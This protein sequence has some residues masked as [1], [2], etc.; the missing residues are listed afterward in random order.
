MAEQN[1]WPFPDRP[2]VPLNPERDGW[3]WLAQTDPGPAHWNAEMARWEHAALICGGTPRASFI[4]SSLFDPPIRYR[5]PCLPPDQ[6]A[7]RVRE[8]VEACADIADHTVT[9]VGGSYGHGFDAGAKLAAQNI[10]SRPAL[11]CP[12]EIAGRVEG[13]DG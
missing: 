12:A 4:A 13:K 2:G 5:G 3:H 9:N 10:R 1:G 6:I 11:P 7:E 8:A